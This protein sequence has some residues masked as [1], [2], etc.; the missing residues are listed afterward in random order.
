MRKLLGALALSVFLVL[1]ADAQPAGVW[2][3]RFTDHTVY[4]KFEPPLLEVW[5][6][7]DRGTCMMIPSV[8]D[9]KEGSIVHSAGTRWSM[10]EH[11]DSITVALPDTTLDY[12]RT[13]T[14][15]S[16]QCSKPEE[17]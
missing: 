1:P 13:I 11:S 6:V 12:Q 16:Q 14:D 17:I 4:L 8:V 7:N 15:P 5:R 3:H 2:K 9:W 10:S